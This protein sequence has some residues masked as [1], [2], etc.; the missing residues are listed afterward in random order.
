MSNFEVK[1]IPR[2]GSI[3]MSKEEQIFFLRKKDIEALLKL[4]YS[5]DVRRGRL[6]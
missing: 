1:I 6:R 2:C 3:K 5:L 4:A